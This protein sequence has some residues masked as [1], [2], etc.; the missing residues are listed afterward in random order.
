VGLASRFLQNQVVETDDAISFAYQD[1]GVNRFAF[2]DRKHSRLLSISG[3]GGDIFSKIIEPPVGKVLNRSFIAVIRPSVLLD[4]LSK[5]QITLDSLMK[6]SPELAKLAP[7]LKETDNPIITI[8][9]L[10]GTSEKLSDSI[11][12]SAKNESHD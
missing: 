11:P 6:I 3:S 9:T 5:K 2:Y 1:C 7:T 4:Q 8:F 10:S 12:F